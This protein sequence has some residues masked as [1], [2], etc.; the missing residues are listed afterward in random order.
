MV[1]KKEKREK[2]DSLIEQLWKHG[3]LTLSRKYG[4]YL[5]SPAPVG[6][7]D[8]DAIAKYK[9]KIAIG[10]TVTEEE[11]NDPNLVTKLI[12]LTHSKPKHSANK[13]TLFV[14]VPYDSIIKAN[15]LLSSLD[16]ETR[17]RIKLITLQ[18]ANE[19]PELG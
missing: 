4:K 7:Y 3:Y 18:D 9:K 5:P 10:I 1:I 15:L 14:G 2:V 16:D 19:K 12:Y 13:V 8:V 17:S 11:L 6:N